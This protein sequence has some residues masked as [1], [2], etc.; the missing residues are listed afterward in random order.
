MPSA[1]QGVMRELRLV[2]KPM[3]DVHTQQR[4][5]NHPLVW[6]AWAPTGVHRSEYEI[7]TALTM[8]GSILWASR[9]GSP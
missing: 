5:V 9:T 2:K 1:K 4:S 3:L 6:S 8:P 7:F